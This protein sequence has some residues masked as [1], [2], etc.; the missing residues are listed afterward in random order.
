MAS[1]LQSTALATSVVNN[2]DEALLVLTGATGTTAYGPWYNPKEVLRLA[3]NIAAITAGNLVV[4]ILGFDQSSGATWTVLASAALS[5]TG[6]TLLTVSPYIAAVAN[7]RAQVEPP[8][9]FAVQV[10]VTTG[11]V[12]GTIGYHGVGA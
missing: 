12:T 4:T 8:V 2:T 3:V 7:Q 10:A 9:W 5:S 11:P 6:L 1:D